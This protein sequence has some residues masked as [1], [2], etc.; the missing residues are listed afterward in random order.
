MVMA[1]GGGR[2]GAVP[3]VRGKVEGRGKRRV[4]A[5]LPGGRGWG[6]LMMSPVSAVVFF[7][8]QTFR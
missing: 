8:E 7:A 6:M 5:G 3:G 1:E 2:R 4:D